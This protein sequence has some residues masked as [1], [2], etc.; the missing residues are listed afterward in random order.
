M[1]TVAITGQQPVTFTSAINHANG[2]TQTLAFLQANAAVPAVQYAQFLPLPSGD[3][4]AGNVPVVQANG[5]TATAWGTI[6]GG[7][8]S[9]NGRSGAVAPQSGDYTA[10]QVGADPS[11]SATAAAAYF[12]RVFAV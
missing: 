2:A 8:T 1:I 11:G 4:V 5:S 12:L 9:F 6:A 7:V 10:A 3:P